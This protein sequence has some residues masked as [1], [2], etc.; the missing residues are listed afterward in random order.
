DGAIG[1][2]V[3]PLHGGMRAMFTMMN[4]ARLSIGAQGPGIAERAFQGAREYATNRRQGRTG[5]VT[6]PA[7]SP[8][9]DHPDVRRMLLTM[10][11]T[12][13]ASRLLLYAA[14]AFDDQAHHAPDEEIRREAQDLSDLLTPA[15][16]AWSTDV[17]F[18]AASLG[19]QVLGGAGYIEEF[20]MA[21]LL[22]DARIAPIYEG[23]NGIQALDLVMRKLPRDDG[24]SVRALLQEITSFIPDPI[25]ADHP[26]NQTYGLL[27]GAVASLASATEW[28]LDR[29]ASQPQ[30]AIAGATPFLELFALT[31][32]GWLMARQSELAITS[33]ASDSARVARECNFFAIEVMSRHTGLTGPIFA[34]ATHLEIAI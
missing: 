11:T 23:T 24:H 12:V 33:D 30:D 18:A 13:Q 1:E 5:G 2:L 14:K 3:G 7:S 6:P 15:A 28:M 19:V 4:A 25:P 8:I 22:R 29:M 32:S 34:G 27:S 31:V 9:I 20:G 16:K 17:G 21:Q 26:L 10:R